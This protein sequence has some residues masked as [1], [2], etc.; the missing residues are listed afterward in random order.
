MSKEASS[1]I[2]YAPASTRKLIREYKSD[3]A[4]IGGEAEKHPTNFWLRKRSELKNSF[5]A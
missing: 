2:E 4:N 1:R 5:L 3:W